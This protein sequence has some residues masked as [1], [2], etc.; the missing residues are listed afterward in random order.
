MVVGDLVKVSNRSVD[1]EDNVQRADSDGCSSS[2]PRTLRK[3]P[4]PRPNNAFR[5][6]LPRES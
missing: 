5:D 6:G 1:T 2:L 3:K 4:T